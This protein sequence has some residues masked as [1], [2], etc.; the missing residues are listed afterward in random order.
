MSRAPWPNPA[1]HE[2]VVLY[3]GNDDS[4]ISDLLTPYRYAVGGRTVEVRCRGGLLGHW[5]VGTRA[6]VQLLERIKPIVRSGAPAPPEIL[7][8][9]AE[10]TDANAAFFD[11][12][13]GFPAA[14]RASTRCWHA[15]ACCWV[16]GAWTPPRTSPRAGRGDRQGDA[17]PTRG[18]PTSVREGEQEPLAL[19]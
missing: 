17:A 13:N 1:G 10:I 15:R 8:L 12:A 3:T 5:A 11:A 19:S 2:E 14:S 16:D 7:G 6:A 9:A 4:I 18:S